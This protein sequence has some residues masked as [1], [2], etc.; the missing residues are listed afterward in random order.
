M[1]QAKVDRYKEEKANRK[2][3]IARNKIKRRVAIVCS[4]LVLVAIV[5]WVGVSGYN[6]YE[7]KKPS[8]TYYCK[9]DAITDYISGLSATEESEE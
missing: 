3:T 6:Y 9:T 8:E 5:A 4:W 2:K 7:S 1:S